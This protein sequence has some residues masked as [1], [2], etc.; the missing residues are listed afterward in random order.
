MTVNYIRLPAQLVP[1][2]V[3]KAFRED[4]L[5]SKAKVV[6]SL[7]ND[8]FEGSFHP[9]FKTRALTDGITKKDI[10]VLENPNYVTLNKLAINFS[11]GFVIVG[12]QVHPEVE[13]YIKASNKPVIYH[14][15]ETYIQDYGAFYESLHNS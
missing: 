12:D 15:P 8:S 1:M 14:N 9:D 13:E 11:D 3:K 7:Y 4:P 2:Y 5:F 6:F 10:S